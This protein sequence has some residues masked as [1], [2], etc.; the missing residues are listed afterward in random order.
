MKRYPLSSGDIGMFMAYELPNN[1]R[2]RMWGFETDFVVIE[3]NT[4]I[5]VSDL[6]GKVDVFSVTIL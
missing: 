5:T 2:E 4:E 3:D 1:E 6:D